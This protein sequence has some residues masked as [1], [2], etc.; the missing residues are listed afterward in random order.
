M[1]VVERFA[2]D[3]SAR[4]R[5]VSL[6]QV[7]GLYTAHGFDACL[8]PGNGGVIRTLRQQFGTRSHYT[9]QCFDVCAG[10]AAVPVTVAVPEQIALF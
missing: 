8:A 1:P 4:Q 5:T 9:G 3:A 7:G 6:E 10:L 2:H